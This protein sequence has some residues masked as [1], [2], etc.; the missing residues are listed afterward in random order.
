MMSNNNSIH[1]S[2]GSPGIET[3][4]NRNQIMFLALLPAMIMSIIFFGFNSLKI[5]ATAVLSCLLFEYLIRK[6][7]LKIPLAFR[8]GPAVICGILLAFNL[9]AG[10][11]VLLVVAGSLVAT[12]ISI[13]SFGKFGRIPFNA[14]L[15]SRLMLRIFFPVQMTTLQAVVTSTDSLTGLSPIGIL[16]EGLKN[17]ETIVQITSGA[18]FPGYFDIFWGNVSGSVGEISA[19]AVLIGGLYLISKKIITWHTPVAV[20]GSVLFFEGMLWIAAPGHFMD[21][22]FHVISGG[23]MFISFF[24]ATDPATSPQS[25]KGKLLAGVIIGLLSIIIRNFGAYPEEMFFA[26]LVVNGLTP[27]INPKTKQEPAE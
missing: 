22:V 11:P 17:G 19:I 14:L 3:V 12:G 24:M 20:L 9:P 4:P 21:P 18:K 2:P 6:Y 5:M 25:P 23:A 8:S 26:V 7:I 27:M 10:L 15:V 16:K 13:I 1:S